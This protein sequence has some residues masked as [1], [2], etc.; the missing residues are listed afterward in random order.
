MNLPRCLAGLLAGALTV[1]FVQAPAAALSV[2]AMRPHQPEAASCPIIDVVHHVNAV[3]EQRQ[4]RTAAEP[5]PLSASLTAIYADG[6]QLNAEQFVAAMRFS[7]G[8]EDRGP[9]VA[10]RLVSLTADEFWPVYLV[11]FERV[12]W[13]HHF[14]EYDSGEWIEGY[15]NETSTWIASYW[16]DSLIRLRRADELHRL[17]REGENLFGACPDLPWRP[18]IVVPSDQAD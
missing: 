3:W 14:D 13:H 9:L 4:G 11:Q 5:P 1:A 15:Q 7:D 8:H 17:A 16:S 12:A 6:A 10:T 18:R 2:A